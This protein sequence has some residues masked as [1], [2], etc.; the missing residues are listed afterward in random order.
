MVMEAIPAR[1]LLAGVLRG[2]PKL[3]PIVRESCAMTALPVAR[4]SRTSW[5]ISLAWTFSKM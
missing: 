5:G 2:L 3:L 1:I 4:R